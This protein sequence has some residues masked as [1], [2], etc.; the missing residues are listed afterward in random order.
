MKKIL[1]VLLLFILAAFTVTS[2]TYAV[3]TTTTSIERD[4]TWDDGAS[5]GY[6]YAVT[7]RMLIDFEII[8]VFM[9]TTVEGSYNG[10]VTTPDWENFAIPSIGGY[11]SRIEVYSTAS[12]TTV[13]A[14][15]VLDYEAPEATEFL[16]G[17]LDV[18]NYAD[19]YIQII[20]MLNLDTKPVDFY[21]NIDTQLNKADCFDFQVEVT[22]T[23]NQINTVDAL[24]MTT[25]NPYQ[26]GLMGTVTSWEYQEAQ[27]QFVASVTYYSEYQLTIENIGFGDTAFLDQVESIDYYTV[28]GEK[29]FQFNYIEN[30]N[31]LITGTGQFATQW[32][33]FA[34]WN[35]TTD[36][37]VV[38]NRA[39][40]LTYL[41]VTDERQIF[42]YLYLPNI[43]VDDVLAVSGNFN[44]RYGYLNLVGTQ[45]Y[46]DWQNALFVLEKDQESY[47][48]QSV[49]NG[50]LP[51]W[52]YDAAAYSLAALTVGSILSM[53]PGLQVIG[54]PLLFV[55]AALMVSSVGTAIDHVVYGKTSE[56]ELITPST[57]LRSTLNQH[58]SIAAGSTTI[59]PST[60]KVHKLFLGLFTEIGTNV[61][62]PDDETLVYTEITWVTN[63][64]VYTL[65]ES[66]IDSQAVLDLEYA[67]GL[68]A[69]GSN[70][71]TDFLA[72]LGPWATVLLVIGGIIVFGSAITA[73]EK[74]LGSLSRLTRDKRKLFI[75]G[76]IV[77]AILIALGVIRI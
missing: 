39:L 27:N 23:I 54:I 9:S 2:Y 63:G 45:K 71:F 21:Y 46:Q 37:L 75:L 24:P 11:Y 51:Q 30:E 15:A 64:Q 34:L 47:G 33:G 25:G 69:E 1:A 28:D 44:Y 7:D 18:S 67:A 77:I 49:F 19:S 68:P 72:S 66:L 70:W 29:Y 42:A 32:N 16:L 4:F 41:E 43:P 3:E 52:S 31:V 55:S 65:D 20:L 50:A 36:E 48:T 13:L 5:N 12:S 60:A 22:R 6:A 57:T 10:S 58:Y 17:E 74:G 73:I 53:V 61:V 56:I 40:A 59:L 8:S 14:S 62:E 76:L 26:R 38:Y 35:L